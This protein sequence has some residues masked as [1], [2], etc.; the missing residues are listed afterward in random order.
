MAMPENALVATQNYVAQVACTPQQALQAY[1]ALQQ[2]TKEV[3]VE[4]SDYGTIP[5]TPKPSLFKPGAEN[6]LRFYGLGH[7]IQ[8]TE[9]IADWE[10]GFFHYEYKVSVHKTFPDGTRSILS[11]CEGSAN[12]KEKRYRNQDPYMLVNTI[13]KMAIKRGLVG[14]TL[15]ATGASGLFTQDIEDMDF[16]NDAQPRQNNGGYGNGRSGGNNGGQ[17][18]DGPSD[19]QVKY[20]HRL[21]NDK[22]ITDDDFRRMMAEMCGGKSSTKDLTKKEA[23]EFINFL[24][25]YQP[26]QSGPKNHEKDPFEGDGKTIEI[27]DSDLGF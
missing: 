22:N 12:S 6:L 10:N 8:K 19:A 27:D 15:Q 25:M 24:N 21:K 16:G 17:G 26:Q 5:G 7:T 11:E 13:Q 20:M 3:L 9:S 4:G 18:A 2:I 1:R 23:S 14:A